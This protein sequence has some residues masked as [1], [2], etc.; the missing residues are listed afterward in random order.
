[1]FFLIFRNL[2]AEKHNFAFDHFQYLAI[3]TLAYYV[4][5][6]HQNLLE[7]NRL[8]K[9]WRQSYKTILVFQKSKLVFKSLTVHYLN[10]DHNNTVVSCKLR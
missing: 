5:N 4:T 8:R 2:S 3:G 7:A 1:M 6:I 9:T 10:Q